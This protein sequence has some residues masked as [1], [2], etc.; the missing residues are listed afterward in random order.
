M[1]IQDFYRTIA[2]V[3]K[4]LTSVEINEYYPIITKE[5]I[6]RKRITRYFVR[7]ANHK[8]GMIV[9][10]DKQQYDGLKN[11]PMY[12]VIEMP[13]RIAGPLDDVPGPP[14]ANTP[15]RLYTGVITANKMALAQAEKEMPGMQYKILNP[16]QF[17]VMN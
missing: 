6:D 17:W 11:H 8:D 3:P 13:W 10:I 4:G 5:D 15:T 12:Q 2:S 14:M 7:Q 9:E 16:T 1:D